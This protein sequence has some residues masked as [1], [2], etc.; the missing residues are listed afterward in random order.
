MLEK[1]LDPVKTAFGLSLKEV[2]HEAGI[3]ESTYKAHKYK[4]AS[5]ARDTNLK[6]SIDYA[7][8]KLHES[9]AL[10]IEYREMLLEGLAEALKAIDSPPYFKLLKNALQDYS[11]RNG[12]TFPEI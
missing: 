8:K 11:K 9:D 7:V 2:L 4:H 5:H 6:P 1:L 12:L 3:H 10:S